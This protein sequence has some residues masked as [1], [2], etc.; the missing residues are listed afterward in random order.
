MLRG[1]F[2]GCRH[3]HNPAALTRTRF[4]PVKGT[5]SE[6]AP[7]RDFERS[8]GGP[9]SRQRATSSTSFRSCMRSKALAPVN[10][11]A[12]QMF[13]VGEVDAVGVFIARHVGEE[14]YRR[15]FVTQIHDFA[16]DTHLLC[17]A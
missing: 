11:A 9:T 16:I 15:I 5:F 2:P 8:E 14:P 13:F 17:F 6:F 10:L 3:V 4:C 1:R 12:R 7:S